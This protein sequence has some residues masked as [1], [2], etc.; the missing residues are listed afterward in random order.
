MES[1]SLFIR[2]GRDDDGFGKTMRNHIYLIMADTAF[3]PMIFFI[4]FGFIAMGY[5]A[6][7]CAF[8]AGGIASIIESVA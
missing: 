7:I 5:R 1:I 2:S 4:E 6:N 3:L 8:I